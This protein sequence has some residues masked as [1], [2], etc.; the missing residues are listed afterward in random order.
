MPA[1]TCPQRPIWYDFSFFQSM[2][3]LPDTPA[4]QVQI[5]W[6]NILTSLEDGVLVVDLDGTVC[7]VNQAAENL[8]Q[9]S[10][11]QILHRPSSQVFKRNPWI[12]AMIEKNLA[13]FH[14][15]TRAEGEIITPWRR[16]VPVGLALFPLQDQTGKTQGIIL[17]LH[18]LTRRRELEEDLKRSDRLATLGTL[19][20]G[21]AHEI[22]NPLG[23]IK[24]AAQLLK[25]T[26]TPDPALREHTDIIIR[27]VDRIDHLMEQLLNL[28]R[29]A[30]LDLGPLNIHEILDQVLLLEK[31]QGKNAKITVRK[32]FDPSLPPIRGD[33]N[34]LTQVFLNI[35]KN[36]LQAMA[37]N[38]D[39]AVTTRMETDF[40]I[41]EPGKERDKF[42]WVDIKD[43]GPGISEENLPHIFSPFFTTKN[44]GTGLGLAVCHRIV[45]EHGGMIRV[46]SRASEGTTFKVSLPVAS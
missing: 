27:E 41:R 3:P 18:D 46:E 10:S 21:L 6:Q 11:S 38:G 7:F 16:H 9:L 30:K 40:H 33:R 22:K 44:H 19:A 42:I 32:H 23:G 1:Q 14:S 12:G 5:S 15:S 17:L 2:K 4:R 25:R 34:Q 35:V 43:N 39:L 29:P 31:Q 36:S 28:S 20:A 37:G 8:I 13:S 26:L 45:K 24:G